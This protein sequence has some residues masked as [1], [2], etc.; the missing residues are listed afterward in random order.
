M[1]F[2][3]VNDVTRLFQAS[4]RNSYVPK[5]PMDKAPKENVLVVFI[6]IVKDMKIT[7]SLG[8]KLAEKKCLLWQSQILYFSLD[9]WF[10]FVS[11]VSHVCLKFYRSIIMFLLDKA[12][13]NMILLRLAL[14]Y[15]IF[16][17]RLYQINN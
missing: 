5:L 8:Y 13:R 14:R 1:I 2:L 3:C 15:V 6:I 9:W 12:H 17:I 11:M 4:S 10:F 7:K 16:Q